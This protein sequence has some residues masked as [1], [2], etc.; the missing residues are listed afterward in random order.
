MVKKQYAIARKNPKPWQHCQPDAQQGIGSMDPSVALDVTIFDTLPDSAA[1]IERDGTI[2]RV[3]SAWVRIGVEND[4]TIRSWEGVN[5]LSVCDSST[6]DGCT[7]S[8]AVAN[9]IRKSMAIKASVFNYTY[10]CQS[11]VGKKCITLHMCPVQVNAFPYYIIS[12]R[13]MI[14]A[15]QAIEAVEPDPLAYQVQGLLNQS[16]LNNALDNEW[17]RD[18]RT[19]TPLSF[20]IVSIDNISNIKVHNNLAAG[21]TILEKVALLVA[22]FGKRPGDHISRSGQAE[23]TLLLGNTCAKTATR[24]ASEI[25]VRTCALQFPPHR[26]LAITVSIGATTMIPKKGVPAMAVQKSARDC[27]NYSKSN[28]SNMTTFCND[29]IKGE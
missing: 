24:I 21:N 7:D 9:G 1:V 2:Q 22:S 28:G 6:S 14:V 3:N 16:S 23:L 10:S 13:E 11:S 5:Y 15:P 27:L 12:H 20:I 17:A 29:D 4:C 25:R 8:E 18:M 26:K 19:A